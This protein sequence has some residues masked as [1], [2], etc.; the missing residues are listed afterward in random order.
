MNKRYLLFAG[1]D[2]YP[3]GGA[4]DFIG[5]YKTKKDALK[6][7]DPNKY[8]YDGGWANIFDLKTERIIKKFDRGIWSDL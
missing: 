3:N 6:A 5:I 4:E 8:D 7:H 1:K 2:Y